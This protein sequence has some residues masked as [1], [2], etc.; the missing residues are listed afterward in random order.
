MKLKASYV[1]PFIVEERK[2]NVA[3]MDVYSRLMMDR[4]IFLGTEI[5]ENVSNTIQAQLLYLDSLNNEPIQIY[6]NSPGGSVPDGLAIYDTM[7]LVNSPVNTICTG[8]AASMAAI[9]LAGGH[10]RAIL[11]H[12]RVMI[13][14]P[15]GGI[16]GQ[17]SDIAIQAEEMRKCKETCVE[18][19]SH[20]TG[21]PKEAL[22]INMD[23]DYWMNAEEALAY[24][25]VDEIIQK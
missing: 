2:L 11:P 3:L 22:Y 7:Q 14:Q 20:H 1:N 15:W 17:A 4:I 18:I 23:R 16:A 12:A 25:I 13:H 8:I 19:L 10:K 21:R 6:I 9:L 5:D 24:N